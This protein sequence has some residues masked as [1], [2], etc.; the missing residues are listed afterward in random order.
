M[1]KRLMSLLLVLV[2]I[3]TLMPSFAIEAAAMSIDD[4]S[5][6]V[7]QSEG[8]KCTLAS[9]VMMLR[10]RAIID[11]NANWADITE[12]TIRSTAWLEGTGLRWDFTYSGMRVIRADKFSSDKGYSFP[13]MSTSSKKAFLINLLGSHP[14]GIEIYDTGIP[15]AVLLTDYDSATDT[16]YCGDP[17]SSTPRRIKLV[18]SWNGTKRGSQDNIIAN[19]DGYWY[20]TN[21]S[22]GGPGLASCVTF[23]DNYEGGKTKTVYCNNNGVLTSLPTTARE[24][25]K[26]D[27]WFTEKT[28]GTQITTSTQFNKDTR[29][30][31]H[32]TKFFEI[33]L[34]ANGG[35]CAAKSVF[36]NESGVLT[37]LPAATKEGY[38][39]D[40]WFTGLTGGTKINAPAQFDKDTKLYAH[41][42][43]LIEITLDANSGACSTKSVFCNENGVLTSELPDATRDDRLFV[44]WFDSPEGGKQITIPYQY[45]GSTKT[46]Y[47]HWKLTP[48]VTFDANGGVCP[49]PGVRVKSDYKIATEL[50]KPMREGYAFLGWYKTGDKNSVTTETEFKQ[51]TTVYASWR[52]LPVVTFDANGGECNVDSLFVDE[53]ENKLPY[54]PEAT[55][56][57]HSCTWINT[58]ANNEPIT[59][60]TV[61]TKDTTVTA[62]WNHIYNEK[63]VV[64]APTCT[65]AGHTELYCVC[66]EKIVVNYVGAYGHKYEGGACVRCGKAAPVGE[67]FTDVYRNGKHKYYYDAIIWAVDADVTNGTSP[68]HFS[69]DLYCTRGQVVTF[70]WRA[71][72][73]PEPNSD[74]CAFKDVHENDYFRKAAIWAV[75]RGITNGVDP[76]HFGPNQICTRAQFVTFLHRFEGNPL[77]VPMSNPFK[78][79]K[80]TDYFYA[81][82]MWAY[83]NNV[84]NGVGVGT[85]APNAN[86]SRAQVVTFIYRA[87]VL[88][89]Q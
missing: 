78:D 17:A 79:V 76:T 67:P 28:G 5:V 89:A 61:F 52:K 47:A 58:S 46:F 57:D 36:C 81:P 42:T 15:H 40:G 68:N 65:T 35:T 51:D 13:S 18:D 55:Y 30:Y 45:D 88:N 29:V 26:F 6:F 50:P 21:K 7:K 22:G 60:D 53:K 23:D 86:C 34:D 19:I 69:P 54:I 25:Y 59:L 48:L 9:A 77:F 24:G 39:F 11:G 84:T 31:A 32:W 62:V 43:K 41:W 3:F 56:A 38:K 63:T 4:D 75:E 83:Q 20:I 73:C 70:L 64:I 1:K 80:N 49:T 72:G 74:E 10:R 33:T 71:A 66:G 82:V 16:F 85:F 2:M 27:G 12:S 44:G 14:E 8:G 87:L 37:S